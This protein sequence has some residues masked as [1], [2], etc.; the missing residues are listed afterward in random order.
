MLDRFLDKWFVDHPREVGESYF[1]HLWAA[2]GFAGT[3]I[4]AGMQCALHALVPGLC[5]KSASRKVER[6]VATMKRQPAPPEAEP[7]ATPRPAA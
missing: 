3:L 5:R 2:L 4:T 1:E 6:L 7:V